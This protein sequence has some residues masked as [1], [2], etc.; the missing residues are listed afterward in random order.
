MAIW[1]GKKYLSVCSLD[2][3]LRKAFKEHLLCHKVGTVLAL[4]AV[5]EAHLIYLA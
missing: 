1:S 2:V 3:F 5:V 4:F